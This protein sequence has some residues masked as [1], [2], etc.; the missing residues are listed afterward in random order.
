MKRRKLGDL[1]VSAIGLGCMGMSTTYGERDDTE[2]IATVHRA[3][4]L[5]CTFLDTSDSY[6]NG[7]NEELLAQAL[8]GKRAQV[9]LATKFGNRG[10]VSADR[11]V[12][13]RPE[14]V[15]EACEKSLKRLNTDVIDL[16][17][18][19]R[20]D[21]LVPIEETV[22]EMARLVEEGKVRFLG[23]SEAG[24]ETIRRAHATHPISALQ[25]EYSLWTR[26]CEAEILPLCRKLGI[27]YVNYAPVGRGFLTGTIASADALIESDGR[28]NHPRFSA[29][30]MAQNKALLAPIQAVASAHDCTMAQ[31]AIAWTMAQGEDIVPI[32]GTKRRRYLE[33]NVAAAEIALTASEIESLGAACPLGVTAGARYPEGQ[34]K[35]LGI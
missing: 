25:T 35:R 4:D 33:E 6:A 29:E 27:G 28:R 11:P 24:L 32:P 31:V 30:N 5:G 16:Y 14:Y 34:M 19:H 2:S 7:L 18:Q 9:V 8:A 17:Y 21:G 1:E 22:G 26:D 3:I 13:G 10:R 12:D 23:L 20:V 15:R